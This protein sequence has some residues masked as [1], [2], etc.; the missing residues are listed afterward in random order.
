MTKKYQIGLIIIG[1]EILSGK[2]MD[3]HFENSKK[4]LSKRGIP[5]TWVVKV[6]DEKKLCEQ[7][8]RF[9]FFNMNSIVFCF[10]GIGSTPDDNT[11][12]ACADALGVN[13]SLNS[14]AEKLINEKFKKLN[15]SITSER[16]QMGEFPFGSKIIPNLHSNIPGFSIKNHYFLPGFPQMAGPMMEW[17]L[18]KNHQ[19]IFSDF[20]EVE[21]FF[22]I[23]SLYESSITPTLNKIVKNYQNIKVYS[24]PNSNPDKGLKTNFTLELGIKMSGHHE[25]ITFQNKLLFDKAINDL[26]KEI[27]FLGGVI[28]NEGKVKR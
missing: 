7:F 25:K 13:L 28:I 6:G 21:Y 20:V 26:K 11:R 5:I 16:L 24:L 14:Q 27:V 18:E 1:D 10:G 23:D 15:I 3:Q 22:Q 17:V 2:R 8:L 12:Q 4:I 19:N 9:S